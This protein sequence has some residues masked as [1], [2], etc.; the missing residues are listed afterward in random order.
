M[1]LF[2]Y[3]QQCQRLIRDSKQRLVDPAD[4]VEYINTARREVAMRS[5]C[6]RRL[7][8]ITGSIKSVNVTLPGLGYT[9]PTVVVSPPD[10]PSG[11]G[12]FPNGAQAT[13][14]AQLGAGG[15]ITGVQMTF[16]GYGYYQ[17][18]FTIVDPTGSGA[19]LTPNLTFI[20]QLNLGQ[21][22]YPFSAVDLSMFP[23]VGSIYMVKS[24]SI[25]YAN[26][27]YSLPCYSFS[28]YQ[29]F[30]RQY[31]FQYQYV[32]TVCCQFGQGT[33]GSFM[34][35]PLPSQAYQLEWDCFCLP[36][37]L[38][39]D[40]S[41][42]AIPQPWTDAVKYFAAHLAALELQ[43]FNSA[44]GYLKLFDQFVTRYGSY[45]R[46]GRVTNPYGRY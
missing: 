4:L 34:V 20:D 14:M 5:Q 31:P 15:T 21:E 13:A 30:I 41:V 40:Q 10:F 16:G 38:L 24:V 35:Y 42:E 33:D 7:P 6:I 19:V 12:T 3:M 17:P 32:P 25:I 46:P 2:A 9:N 27:R 11:Q 37:D 36:S 1:G 45:A 22:V 23:G 43:N 29:A 26:Y 39:D 44:V 8:P 18:T 28:T